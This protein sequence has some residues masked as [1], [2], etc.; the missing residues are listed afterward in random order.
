MPRMP[1]T[2]NSGNFRNTGNSN[3]LVLAS[4]A[5]LHMWGVVVA[6]ITYLYV[7]LVK[8]ILPMLLLLLLLRYFTPAFAPLTKMSSAVL[9]DAC[10]EGTNVSVST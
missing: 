10:C 7:G 5:F 6:Y 4:L 2:R 1:A 9:D 3:L 8:T